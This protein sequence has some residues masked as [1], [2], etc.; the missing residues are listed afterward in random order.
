MTKMRNA[1][2][3]YFTALFSSSIDL[4]GTVPLTRQPAS[5]AHITGNLQPAALLI[6]ANAVLPQPDDTVPAELRLP[7]V[8]GH[9]VGLN[10]I[11]LLLDRLSIL[12]IK[13]WNLIHRADSPSRAAELRSGPG[14]EMIDALAAAQPGHSS[15]NS[16]ITIHGGRSP[17]GSFVEAYRGVAR[18]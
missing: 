10:T 17:C 11:G 8:L 3:Q 12:A 15:Y 13:H 16:K 7:A 18:H 4:V 6:S 1:G 2:R 14:Q 5:M 9:P